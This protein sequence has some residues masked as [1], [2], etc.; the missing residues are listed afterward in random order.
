MRV[1]VKTTRSAD[2]IKV[3]G[4]TEEKTGVLKADAKTQAARVLYVPDA[5]YNGDDH[6]SFKA[7]DCAFYDKRAS[8]EQTV[9][10]SVRAVNDKPAAQSHSVTLECAPGVADTIALYGDD[11]DTNSTP[12]L[13]YSIATIPD[14][15]S[16][17]D[18]NTG[19]VISPVV[20]PASLLGTGVELLVNYSVDEPPSNFSFEFITTD[21]HGAVSSSS[22]TVAVTCRATQCDPGNYFDM[23]ARVCSS[24]PAGTFAAS[25][26]AVRSSC[27]DC[28]V[29][30]F[31][32]SKGSIACGTCAFGQ[33]A[34]AQGSTAC[35]LCPS[36]ATCRDTSTLMVNPGMWRR[37]SDPLDIYEC[38]FGP[39]ACLGG[40]RTDDSCCT[41][42]YGGVLCAVC[43]PGYIQNLNHCA[44]CS[45]LHVP[46][47]VII[48]V[49]TATIVAFTVWHLTRTN[50]R[51]AAAMESISL[52]VP[53]KIYFSTCQIL[54]VFATLLSDV[55]FQPLKGFLANLTFATDL[56]ELFGG[57]GVSCAHHGMR[58]FRVRLLITTITP[59]VLCLCIALVY[60][61]RVLLS[62]PNRARALRRVHATFALLLL[63]VILPS[64]SSMIFKAFVRDSRP[65]GINGEQ[66]LIVDYAGK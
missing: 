58:Y 11:I 56:A 30:T 9:T 24:C 54:G 44:D 55:L 20:L 12:S 6:L 46:T 23:N 1:M 43:Q 45:S 4:S 66:Y 3:V 16:L 28:A 63:Y 47:V 10:I 26:T 38:P 5:D 62:H 48:V 41:E 50:N 49:V 52:S 33:V 7:C 8:D 34:L 32:A 53:L 29:G 57:F 14:G 22:A 31:T 37:D 15:A 21:E 36:R 59:I 65:L 19:E 39:H 42:G 25:G 18:A 64:T 40:N 60:G 61:C 27:D 13:M 35:D 51:F 17:Y 2:Y